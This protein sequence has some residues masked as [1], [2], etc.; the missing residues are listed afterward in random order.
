MPELQTAMAKSSPC[1]QSMSNSALVTLQL[2]SDVEETMVP[3]GTAPFAWPSGV[4]AR[5]I[6]SQT[7]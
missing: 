1:R 3:C 6:E 2:F 5:A 7:L 4:P